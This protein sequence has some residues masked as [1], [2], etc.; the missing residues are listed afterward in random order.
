MK[1][2]DTALI[3]GCY[4][5]II[6]LYVWVFKTFSELKESMHEH[7]MQDDRHV[8]VDDLVRRGDCDGRF[9]VIQTEIAG[10]KT[11]LSRQDK[12]IDKMTDQIDDGFSRVVEALKK[13]SIR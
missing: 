8:K 2:V 11:D 9:Q 5:A 13:Q 7:E 12:K 4:I 10:V 3:A 6:G 1:Y